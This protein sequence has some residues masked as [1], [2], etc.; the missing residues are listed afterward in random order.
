MAT[1]EYVDGTNLGN[2]QWEASNTRVSDEIK[3][4]KPD[5][6]AK[7]DEVGVPFRHLSFKRILA[8]T[9]LFGLLAISMLPLFLIGGSLRMFSTGREILIAEDIYTDIGGAEVY[10]WLALV[11][12]LALAAVAPFAGAVSDLIGRRYVALQGA[13]LIIIGMIVVGTAHRMPIAIAGMAISGVGA[14]LSQ[15][16]GLAGVAELVPVYHRGKYLGKIFL[17]FSPMAASSAYGSP[18]SG[19]N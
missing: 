3:E 18:S 19:S 13:G 8:I 1:A 7:V 14:G 6:E 15:V 4:S 17:L 10:T 9:S 16:V 5:I 11:N 12:S 2:R